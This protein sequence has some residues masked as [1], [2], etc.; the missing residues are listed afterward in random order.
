MVIFEF[1]YC[2]LTALI[3]SWRKQ[4]HSVPSYMFILSIVSQ[5]TLFSKH[6]CIYC[7]W[8]LNIREVLVVAAV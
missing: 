2:F 7:D 4:L 1:Y 3:L 8:F 5:K 6:S